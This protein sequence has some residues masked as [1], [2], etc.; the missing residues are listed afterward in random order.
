MRDYASIQSVE[1]LLGGHTV[2]AE[3]QE[4]RFVR[5]LALIRDLLDELH[6]EFE[7]V[8]KDSI[9]DALTGLANRRALELRLQGEIVRAKRYRHELALVMMDIDYFKRYNDV[10]GHRAGDE[11]LRRLGWMIGEQVREPD[12]VARYG[13][14]EFALLLPETGLPGAHALVQRIR[15]RMME[16]GIPLTLSYGIAV[17]PHHAEDAE[18]LLQA[19][20][21]ALYAAKKAGRDSVR[22]AGQIRK[23]KNGAADRNL[24]Q[25]FTPT[26]QRK[27]LPVAVGFDMAADKPV[28]IWIGK[29]LLLITHA[30]EETNLTEDV[31]RAFIVQTE[32]GP[33][34]LI[35]RRD[36]WYLEDNVSEP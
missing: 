14:E 19:A 21:E 30:M 36:R 3:G 6:Q 10:Y 28:S 17:Y 13:G 23:S 29:S 32:D 5:I 7:R 27:E 25:F 12:L 16:D 18:T 26:T 35:R 11:I 1:H 8:R 15:D 9:T 34:R 2:P 20:D 22:D 31:D 24:P 4:P 33:F